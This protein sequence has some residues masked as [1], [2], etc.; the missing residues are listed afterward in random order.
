[1]LYLPLTAFRLKILIELLDGEIGGIVKGIG[2]NWKQV[3]LWTNQ[4][5]LHEIDDIFHSRVNE[6]EKSK[7]LDMLTRYQEMCG[8]REFGVCSQSPEA[9]RCSKESGDWIFCGQ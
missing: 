5:Q 8:T 4:F 2:H 6:D 1:M 3:A 9:L 7:A